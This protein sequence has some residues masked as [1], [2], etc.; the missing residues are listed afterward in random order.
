VLRSRYSIVIYYASESSDMGTSEQ[1]QLAVL[2]S[3]Y[4]IVIYYASESSDMGTSE[5]PQHL[6]GPIKSG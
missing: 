5:Q 4:S 3:R 6:E 2:R 1:P